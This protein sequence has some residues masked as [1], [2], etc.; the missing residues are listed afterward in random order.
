MRETGEYCGATQL[1]VTQPA[2]PTQHSK[3]QPKGLSGRFFRQTLQVCGE[4]A[5]S[6]GA[7]YHL[8]SV[9][10]KLYRNIRMRLIESNNDPWIT[11]L[12]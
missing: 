10:E 9:T 1:V 2:P 11:V 3:A 6:T 7:D 5:S 12:S 8:S 4:T